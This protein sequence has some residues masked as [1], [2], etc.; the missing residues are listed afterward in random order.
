MFESLNKNF[1]KTEL[2]F[3][4]DGFE[5]KKLKN[6]TPDDHLRIYGFFV[7]SSDYGKTFNLIT[8]SC[9]LSLPARYAEDG[10]FT[11]E[12]KSAFWSGEYEITN[13]H[14]I[15]SKRGKTFKFEIREIH[16]KT[17]IPFN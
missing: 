14:E 15:D 3:S 6:F 12:E 7:T 5:F 13:I 4:T 10:K 17:D 9:Y 1:D 11:S 16:E 8:D 2:P